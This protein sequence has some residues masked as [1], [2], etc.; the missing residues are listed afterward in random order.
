MYDASVPT[1][2]VVS[3]L[4]LLLSGPFVAAQE[5]DHPKGDCAQFSWDM[6]RELELMRAAPAA[7]SAHASA[8]REA[9]AVPLEQRLDVAL[10]PSPQVKLQVAPRRE[11]PADSR[12]GVLKVRV[13][14]SGSYRVSASQRLWIEVVGP[15]GAVT[16]SKFTMQAGC[17][18][19]RK[20]VA[21]PLEA[22][23]D[24]WIELSGSPTASPA[25]LVTP[26]R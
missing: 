23:T 22:E 14:R 15:S 1:T 20:S 17:E 6:A 19:L 26:D 7:V 11:P 3:F 8:E 25:L 21:F 5:H 16:S 24:Y 18:V 4:L 10:L 9:R 2:V 13:P 12:A